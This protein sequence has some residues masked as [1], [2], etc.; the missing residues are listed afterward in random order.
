MYRQR[1]DNTQYV[2]ITQRFV[3]YARERGISPAALA[4]AW[5]MSHPLVSAALFGA[6]NLEQFENTLTCLDHKLSAENRREITALSVDPPRATDR[7][8]MNAMKQ[9]GW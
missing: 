2:E 5:V 6:R 8:S 1:Y 4:L 9:R 7:E 3:A